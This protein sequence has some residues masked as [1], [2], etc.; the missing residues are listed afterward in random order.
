[1][2]YI[3]IAYLTAAFCVV[4]TAD[5]VKLKN[6]RT[7]TGIAR[8]E[9]PNRV[10]VETRFG[11]IRVPETEVQAIE[12]GRS[13]L[14]EYKER[15]DALGGCP[16]AQQLFELAQWAEERGLTRY[17]NGLLM[18]VLQLEP[19][20]AEARALLGYVRWEGN[21][22]FPR[23]RSTIVQAREAEHRTVAKR[24]VP[25]RRTTRPVEETPYSLGLPLQPDRSYTNVYPP[26]SPYNTG[27]YS[28]GGDGGYVMSIG[29]VTPGGA[30]VINYPL[31]ANVGR[32]NTRGTIGNYRAR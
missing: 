26:R 21:W 12:P 17:V 4:A 29:G 2:K 7:L 25:V 9:E 32:M 28:S 6:G 16:S 14:H 11:D 30:V 10:V 3:L 27:G 24:T 23:E 31:R 1:M 8:H 19:D 15:L 20:H 18:Q 13:D 22:M 5:E